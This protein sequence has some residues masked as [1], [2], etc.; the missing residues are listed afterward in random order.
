MIFATL[1]SIS[2]PT[3]ISAGAVGTPERGKRAERG[4]ESA[5]TARNGDSRQTGFTARRRTRRRLKYTAAGAA[6][7]R[8]EKTLL[9]E[10]GS[11]LSR[12]R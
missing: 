7:T 8:P 2:R 6:P 5:G 11:V 3:Y 4:T 10:S 1:L 9:M 12:R